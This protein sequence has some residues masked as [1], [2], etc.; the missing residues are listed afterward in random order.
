MSG[1][2]FIPYHLRRLTTVASLRDQEAVWISGPGGSG[3]SAIARWLH[4]RGPRAAHPFVE[5]KPFEP[6]PLQIKSAGM[7]TLYFPELETLDETTLDY[8]NDLL[9]YRSI[10]VRAP[11]ITTNQSTFTSMVHA[12]VIFS[13]L[14]TPQNHP[15][16]DAHFAKKY[17][18][19]IPSLRERI[20]EDPQ[21]FT[22]IAHQLLSELTTE[23]KQHDI[24]TI[25]E[26][27]LGYLKTLEWKGNIRELRETLR[28]AILKHTELA[29]N[30]NKPTNSLDT[31]DFLLANNTLK[32]D[33]KP[34]EVG[35]TQSISE[36]SEY[37]L[38]NVTRLPF[39][40]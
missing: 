32:N 10:T 26:D 7:G 40:F 35:L 36:P 21:T 23:I 9:R 16:F 33:L 4:D 18:I 8:L 24:H 17:R 3:K 1:V 30:R 5:I 14:T 34:M 22:D 15:D 38:K 37:Y 12:R 19:H 29:K 31:S 2:A 25:S 11:A 28:S 20:D 39:K 27:A 6:I 13:S